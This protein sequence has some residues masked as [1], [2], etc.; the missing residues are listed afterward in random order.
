MALTLEMWTA[1]ERRWAYHLPRLQYFICIVFG[2]TWASRTNIWDTSANPSGIK[3][4]WYIHTTYVGEVDVQC[5]LV[6][7]Y[8][9]WKVMNPAESNKEN[10]THHRSITARRWSLY[11]CLFN[12]R[13]FVN[14]LVKRFMKCSLWT[15]LTSFMLIQ[16][17]NCTKQQTAPEDTR[18]IN[19]WN[20]TCT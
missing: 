12:A 19:N 14:D 15:W 13:V 20:E 2:K 18:K 1:I 9:G 11:L 3:R 16:G 6:L 4:E 17:G 7:Y 5:C 8:L 10:D